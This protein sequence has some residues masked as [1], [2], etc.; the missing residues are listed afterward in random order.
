MDLNDI[1][2]F[3]RIAERG[4][5]TKA[6][7]ALDLSVS[8][9]SLRLAR[10]EKHL[11]T[12][13][14]ER[15]TRDMHLTDAGEKYFRHVS[16]AFREIDAGQA[17]LSSL[18]T[19]IAGR[20]RMTAPP[21]MSA[22]V[23]P[24]L[25]ADF[26]V[27]HPQVDIDLD[28][29]GR[30][31]DLVGDGIDLALR[32]AKPPDTRLVAKRIGATAGKF[33]AAPVLFANRPSPTLPNQLV[34]WPMLVIASD[35]VTLNWQ[36]HSTSA[37]VEVSFRPRLAANNYQVVVAATQSGIGIGNLP[38]FMGD[39]LVAEGKLV[40]VLPDW[41]ARSV[42]LYLIYPSQKSVSLALRALID[43]LSSPLASVFTLK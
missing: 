30:V 29:T 19:G 6:A 15:T 7:E 9:V 10:L 5:L 35:A 32:V 39:P 21:L 17:V 27:K 22:T 41:I 25:I 12:R 38:M 24:G 37:K 28:A 36:L 31:V 4:S 18:S 34:D 14:I 40:D 16:S 42:S 33:Y 8:A 26:L 3:I 20:I 43:H 23:L 2:V 1:N 11:G 13:L